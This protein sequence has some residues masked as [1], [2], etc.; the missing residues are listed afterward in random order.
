MSSFFFRC[1][2]CDAMC[3]ASCATKYAKICRVCIKKDKYKKPLHLIKKV[4]RTGQFDCLSQYELFELHV[5]GILDKS[6]TKNQ[7]L[8]DLKE[9]VNRK[10]SSL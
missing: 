7:L 2:I 8:E 3:C 1:D 5:S 4:K 9:Y 6:F 10:F